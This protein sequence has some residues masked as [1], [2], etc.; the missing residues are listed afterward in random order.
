MKK[1]VAKDGNTVWSFDHDGY[2]GIV[3]RSPFTGQWVCSIP[4]PNDTLA[5]A[6]KDTFSTALFSAKLQH[7]TELLKMKKD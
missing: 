3:Y 4:L 5:T 7:R 2:E 1:F 6:V